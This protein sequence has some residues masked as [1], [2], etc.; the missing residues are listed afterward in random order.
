MTCPHGVYWFPVIENSLAELMNQTKEESCTDYRR[1][2][3]Y[4]YSRSPS[5]DNSLTILARA[6]EAL[7]GA[8]IAIL[9]L[10]VFYLL[11]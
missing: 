8:R 5:K 9:I 11:D 2:P 4:S 3:R 1:I 7:T 10:V 6:G